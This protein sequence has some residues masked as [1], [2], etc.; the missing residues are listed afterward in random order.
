MK[1]KIK[2][3]Q[4]VNI[5]VIIAIAVAFFA[6]GLIFF[7]YLYLGF[8]LKKSS[9]NESLEIASYTARD[10]AQSVEVFF[11][12]ALTTDRTY[13]QNILVYRQNKLPRNVIYKLLESSLKNNPEFLAIWTMLD[14][15]TYDNK[16]RY[17]KNLEK[18]NNN[19]GFGV[20]YY[21]KGKEIIQEISDT[22]AYYQDYY[23]LP[24]K[25]KRPVILEPYYY[26]YNGNEL[27]HYETSLVSPVI[28]SADFIGVV[29]I[30][31][32]LYSLQAKFI[33]KK[34][35]NDGF[36]TILSNSGA[37]V[38]HKYPRY[39]EKNISDYTT[40]ENFSVMDSIQSGREFSTTSIS[41]FTGK[42][43]IRYF[44]PINMEYMAAPWYIMIEIP[45]DK[46]ME[47][48]R[49]LRIISFAFLISSLF[50]L[51]YLVYNISDRRLKEKKLIANLTK[52]NETK[53]ELKDY[54]EH[55]E[56]LVRGRTDEIQK[57][58]EELLVSNDQLHLVNDEILKQKN[59]MTTTL[60][61]LQ[62]AQEKLVI[63]EKM[64]SLGMLA[65]GVAHEIN[66]PLNFILGGIAGLEN[67]LK[68]NL[69]EH[70]ENVS[71]L[72][73][74]VNTGVKRSAKIISSLSHYSRK[75]DLN[76]TECDIH[77][78]IDNCLT[79][80][81]SQLK[82]KIEVERF[83]TRTPYSITGSEGKL[84]QAFLNI[85]VNAIQSIEKAGKI[86][87]FT[88]L[89]KN[90]LIIKIVDTGCGMSKS[91]L[92]KIFDPF[93]TTKD[94]G[95]GIG[96]GLSITFKIIQE[97]NGN[98]EYKSEKGK[99]TSVKVKIP[100]SNSSKPGTERYSVR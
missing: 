5:G 16:D 91:V 46:A 73:N 44:Y 53:L 14:P 92:E 36:I 89:E 54:Q 48:S 70:V 39:L 84:H 13:A 38:F 94:P 12:D 80:L 56:D 31:I 42:K 41:M 1:Y 77:F 95:K 69:A 67:Y 99:G 11:R 45:Y 9:E 17:F 76:R 25:F 85:I 51:S 4:K 22:L 82:N 78:I 37:I 7:Q 6:M 88:S 33:D 74:A 20:T 98:I 64:A 35:Y 32:D 18:D 60:E 75:D 61:Q 58:N 3:G 81:D 71:P 19:G 23:T 55:L 72:I 10:M 15:N 24:R 66:N 8:V 2:I 28:D 62:S 21:F 90:I 49:S 100:V 29:G 27:R 43:A 68:E 83:Y 65:A 40:N 26:Q 97:H 96:L 93:F 87:I 50:L 86:S 63:S 47:R 79:M 57:L 30:D 59:E 52:L 34:V